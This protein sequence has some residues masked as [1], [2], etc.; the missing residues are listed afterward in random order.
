VLAALLALSGC[1]NN[2]HADMEQRERRAADDLYHAG[3]S[4]AARTA[5]AR[6]DGHAKQLR[7]SGALDCS[8]WVLGGILE[9][10]LTMEKPRR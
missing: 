10:V 4:E 1:A 6:A 3:A 8:V 7:C 2:Y 5:D 9:S